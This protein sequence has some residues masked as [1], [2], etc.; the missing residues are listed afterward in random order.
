MK[1]NF[2]KFAIDACGCTVQWQSVED[3]MAQFI[4]DNEPSENESDPEEVNDN[5]Y[6]RTPNRKKGPVTGNLESD[7]ERTIVDAMQANCNRRGNTG[8]PTEI[9]DNQTDNPR[10][11]ENNNHV[12]K[13]TNRR[14]KM[15]NVKITPVT[16]GYQFSSDL[17]PDTG[18]AET[19]IA[20]N[21][22]ERQRMSILPNVRHLHSA[23]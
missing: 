7:H 10:L 20:A 5:D 17:Y 23:G 8:S 21:V 13:P 12:G 19:V 11:C 1:S 14:P 2:G 16:N 15:Y 6:G 4:I 9:L 22:T 3:A 18:C